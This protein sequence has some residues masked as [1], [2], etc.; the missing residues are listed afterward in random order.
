MK[1]TTKLIPGM[2]VQLKP[3]IAKSV[4]AGCFMTI[5]E[6]KS[7]GASGYIPVPGNIGLAYH[8]AN[9]EEMELIGKA[10]W[11]V[12]ISDEDEK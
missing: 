5:T 4:F 12:G 6:P 2:V 9:F 7:F 8:L 1:P 3:S 11:A 10:V